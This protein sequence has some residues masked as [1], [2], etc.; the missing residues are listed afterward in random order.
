[1]YQV[2]NAETSATAEG[3]IRIHWMY[4]EPLKKLVDGT[5]GL[6]RL[7]MERSDDLCQLPKELIPFSP[8]AL[9]LIGKPTSTV[10]SSV[11][12]HQTQTMPTTD[13][14]QPSRPPKF[15]TGLAVNNDCTLQLSE[16]GQEHSFRLRP[17]GTQD[18]RYVPDQ[19]QANIGAGQYI[20]V[21]LQ[22]LYKRR[23]AITHKRRILDFCAKPNVSSERLRHVLDVR[24]GLE[25]SACSGHAQRVS[26]EQALQLAYPQEASALLNG[27]CKMD[28]LM[29]ATL[30][31]DLG[32]TGVRDK[33]KFDLFWPL[34]LGLAEAFTH[35][36]PPRAW[37]D[38]LKDTAETACFAVISPR[39]LRRTA[40]QKRMPAP[41]PCVQDKSASPVVH[42]LINLDPS[43]QAALPL[44]IGARV[45]LTQ[46]YLEIRSRGSINQ[47]AYY[48]R[49]GFLNRI[50]EAA[51]CARDGQM[52]HLHKEL[53]AVQRASGHV[54]SVCIMDRP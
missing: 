44:A 16:Y 27:H 12:L 10:T 4:T 14:A 28:S 43:S 21:G 8:S 48:E 3:H 23:P 35:E 52:G 7:S 37:P 36:R 32:D 46:G 11:T 22:K 53:V 50:E 49:Y 41:C 6:S 33:D 42:T 34:S 15:S 13:K 45:R 18:A 47:L 29:L 25:M 54:A 24:A 17:L 1:M 19:L 5:T 51:M 26:L 31:S 39:C 9:L 40:E 20:N 38:L 30:L 2:P